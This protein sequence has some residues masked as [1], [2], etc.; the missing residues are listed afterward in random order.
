MI[1][2]FFVLSLRGDIIITREYRYDVPK[3]STETFF[4]KVKFWG[5]EGEDAPP[6]FHADGVNYFHV[7]TG[8]LLFMAT[9]RKNVAP[10]LVLELIA[11]VAAVAKDYCGVL[12][13]DALRKNFILV[14][15]LLDEMIDYGCP[16]N[17]ST[18]ALK[19]YIFNEPIATDPPATS[20]QSRAKS[21][22]APPGRG[23][24]TATNKSV[25]SGVGKIDRDEIFVDVVERI[26]VTFNSS[27][28]VQSQEVDGSIM[29]KNFLSKCSDIRIAL[30]ED[31]IIIRDVGSNSGSTG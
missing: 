2:Q 6:T 18:E 27:G 14:Y 22:F 12:S 31:L 24:V 29:M 7:K 28:Y 17:T 8:G 21:I 4:R 1:S 13:E 19:P 23:I 3:T 10:S 9:T 5:T 11:R 16:M 20:I 15:E 30:N 25:K 26:S